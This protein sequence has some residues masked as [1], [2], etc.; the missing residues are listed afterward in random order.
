MSSAHPD[1]AYLTWLYSRV[2]SV[3][4]RSRQRT[5]WSLLRQLYD[6]EFVC[7]HPRDENRVHDALALRSDFLDEEGGFP[8]RSWHQMPCSVLEVLVALAQRL[9][10]EFDGEPRQ[11]FT[12]FLQNLELISYNDATRYSPKEVDDIL[13]K[14]VWRKYSRDG[15]G[16]LFPL[17]YP[18]QDQ[19]KVEIWYQANG[20]LIEND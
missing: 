3:H 8:D 7:T 10:V 16:G 15:R 4:L 18:D 5:Y 9:S 14:L 6:Y 17:R 11:W 19:T 1:E 20:Y 2:G 13:N 12:E